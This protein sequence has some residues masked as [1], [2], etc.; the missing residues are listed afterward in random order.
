MTL[1][2]IGK[3]CYDIEVTNGPDKSGDTVW[4]KGTPGLNDGTPDTDAVCSTQY[5]NDGGG[6]I[7]YIGTCDADGQ[8]DPSD[9]DGERTNS[10]TIWFDG[11][12]DDGLAYIDPTGPN[13]WRNPCVDA[14]G[15]EIG[16]TLNVL[17]EENADALV[18]FNFTV[19]REANQG[20]FDIAVNFGDIFCSAKFDCSTE[21]DGACSGPGGTC[22]TG[23]LADGLTTCD[24]NADCRAQADINLLHDAA[25]ERAKTFV[26]GFA[27]TAGPG[28]D[29]Q[30]PRCT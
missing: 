14:E 27:C 12:Y 19:M 3:V 17:C 13:G 1:P 25:G 26:L 4:S 7:T 15:D 20:F 23:E 28:T 30:T 24:T 29:V 10:V 6:D 11:I 2:S 16:C 18:E 8:D 5:G 9:A 21:I 22:T